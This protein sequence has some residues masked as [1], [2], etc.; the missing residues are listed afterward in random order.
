MNS[1]CKVVMN[2]FM[3]IFFWLKNDHENAVVIGTHI[4]GSQIAH[5]IDMITQKER[6]HNTNEHC[7]FALL[8]IP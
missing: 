3:G 8:L 4:N 1:R 2:S 6:T 5:N 7:S